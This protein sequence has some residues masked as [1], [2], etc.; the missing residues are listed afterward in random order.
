MYN[1]TNEISIVVMDRKIFYGCVSD[2]VSEIC[3]ALEGQLLTTD[4]MRSLMTAVGNVIGRDLKV[5]TR[6]KSD[7]LEC[8]GSKSYIKV[9][10]DIQNGPMKDFLLSISCKR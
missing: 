4:Q 7:R 6:E 5:I 10:N 1:C 2:Q 3:A 9:W 8:I